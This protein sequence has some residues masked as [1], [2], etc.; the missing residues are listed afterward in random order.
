MERETHIVSIIDYSS[1]GEGVARLEDGRVLFVKGAA[2]GDVCK[3]AIVS[4]RQRICFAEIVRIITP[5]EFRVRPDCPVYSICGGC[6]FRH[7]TYEEE[8]RAKLKRVNDALKRLAG[9]SLQAD[10]MLT[11]GKPDGYRNK[12]VLH[13]AR[14]GKETV[15]GFYRAKTNDVCPIE[16]CPLLRGEINNALRE[17][18]DKKQFS[19]G[20]KIR[21]RVGSNGLSPP[22]EETL[23][24]LTFRMSED[25]FF[26]V[27]TD[28]ALLL[29]RKAK[30]YAALGKD[31]TLLDIYC[32]VGTLT[33]FLGRDAKFALGVESNLSAVKDAE[34]N[35]KNAKLSHIEF[36]CADAA[37]WDSG[38][39]KPDCVVTDPP[40]AG[41]STEAIEKILQLSP[42]RIIYISCDPATLARDIK[43][44]SNDYNASEVC[45]IDMFPRTANVEC[46]V[47][48]VSNR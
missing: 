29:Y 11:A 24:G 20:E 4:E 30:Q 31:E 33:L 38:D 19:A 32:G 45:V 37:K 46:C 22:I 3:V 16:Y 35:A 23:D 48:L 27:N 21:F 5:S 42:K 8:L 2:R 28:A 18:W 43:R 26:Q 40:R 25:S 14:Q 44:L 41:M 12:A 34:I 10:E 9:I 47:L 17:L 1:G 39:F 6:D 7:I 15:I 36:I 13:T